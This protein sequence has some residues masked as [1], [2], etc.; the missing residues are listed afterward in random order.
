MKTKVSR[1]AGVV[2]PWPKVSERQR[3]RSLKREAVLHAAVESFN[4]NGYTSTSLDD[5][6][7]ALNVTKPTIYHYF[8]SKDEVLFECVKLGL[9]SIQ[10]A[11]KSAEE[12]DANG[13]ERLCALM[14]GYAKVMTEDFGMCVARTAEHEL[15]ETSRN[16]FRA[17]KREVDDAVRAVVEHGMQDGS[18][19]QGNSR[20]VTFTL[21]GALNWIGH[22]FDPSGEMTPDSVARGAVDVL[23]NGIAPGPLSTPSLVSMTTKNVSDE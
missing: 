5:V 13:R 22:W 9:E 12:S 14:F 16:R 1:E 3:M 23:I 6:A 17:L 8:S 21:T 18:I 19:P 2:S 20:M 10:K 7:I 15:S 11:L 4:R